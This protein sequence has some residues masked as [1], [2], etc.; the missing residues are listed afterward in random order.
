MAVIIAAGTFF[1]DFLDKVNKS[2]TPIYTIILSLISIFLALYY[3]LKK[4]I[5]QNEKK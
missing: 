2:D 1:G 5:N 4:I 3:V